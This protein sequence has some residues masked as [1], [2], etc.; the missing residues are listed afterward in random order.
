MLYVLQRNLEKCVGVVAWCAFAQSNSMPMKEVRATTPMLTASLSPELLSS[1]LPFSLLE[2]PVH[3]PVR[4]SFLAPS[5]ISAVCV[6]MDSTARV[7]VSTD[8]VDVSTADQLVESVQVAEASSMSQVMSISKSRPEVAVLPWKCTWLGPTVIVMDWLKLVNAVARARVRDMESYRSISATN[9]G[10]RVVRAG[11]STL[12]S[13]DSGAGA[14]VEDSASVRKGACGR[15][16]VDC[17]VAKVKRKEIERVTSDS[18]A[19]CDMV[20]RP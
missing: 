13:D 17:A 7:E 19:A 3:F 15:V 5:V 2:T 12:Q 16:W 10:I 11:S 8:S 6:A 4:S 20:A 1:P 18:I 9:V 14:G